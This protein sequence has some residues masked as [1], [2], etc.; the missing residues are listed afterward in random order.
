[1]KGLAR[2]LIRVYPAKWRARYG[3]EF[4]ALLEDSSSGWPIVFDL[5]K[6]AI[7]MQL[8]IPSFP[9]LALML[10]F[11]GL[12]IGLLVSYSVTPR[13]ISRSELSIE[14]APGSLRL[15]DYLMQIEQEVLSRISLSRMILGPHLD[16]YPEERARMPLEDVIETMRTR[17]RVDTPPSAGQGRLA[18]SIGFAYRDRMKARDTVQALISRFSEA[19]LKLRPVPEAGDQFTS[20]Q[21]NLTVLDPPSMP[22]L[23]P[24]RSVSMFF[25]FVA[26]IVAA[27]FVAIFRRRPPPV[28]LFAA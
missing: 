15:G 27:S 25:G 6:G 10:S 4:E 23:L 14:G 26:G 16:L 11:A 28:T 24:N 5:L 3:E 22:I 18:F 19:S 21:I 7:R 12:L 13:Y 20:A 2:F 17:I 1:M 9:K 8:S